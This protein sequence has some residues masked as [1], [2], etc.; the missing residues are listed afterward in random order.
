MTGLEAPIA[1]MVADGWPVDRATACMRDPE[2]IATMLHVERNAQATQ[3]ARSGW[4]ETTR[5]LRAL[6]R[7]NTLLAAMP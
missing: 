5:S 6:E 3:L 7:I 1:F 4:V 2:G